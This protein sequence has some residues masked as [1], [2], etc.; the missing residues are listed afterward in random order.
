MDHTTPAYGSPDEDTARLAAARAELR[1][2]ARG[3]LRL[4]DASTD[5]RFIIDGRDGS[6]VLPLHRDAAAAHEAVLHLPD[7]SYDASAV[8]LLSLEPIALEFDEAFDR[9][10]AYH[11]DARAPGWCRGTIDSVRVSAVGVVD[12]ASL[13]L[14]NPLREREPALV[15]T[16]NADRDR[17]RRAA[18]LLTGV[19]PIEALGVGVD[20][21]GF[22]VRSRHGVL[23]VPFP[24]PCAEADEA[25]R[26]IAALL[27]GAA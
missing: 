4:D 1:A 2:H 27:D 3:V 7:D 13:G 24:A 5:L 17:L 21:L 18:E 6:L 26:V 10:L 8:C 25:E 20:D 19:E 16:L 15:R 9:H 12:G 11:G 22:D 14:A 23:R